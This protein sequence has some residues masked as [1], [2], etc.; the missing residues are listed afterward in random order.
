MRVTEAIRRLKKIAY[1]HSNIELMLQDAD[2]RL[3]P[4]EIMVI[5]NDDIEG[6][7]DMVL[8]GHPG[9]K[10]EIAAIKR[11]SMSVENVSE[12]SREVSVDTGQ[13]ENRYP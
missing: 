12:E 7:Q 8:I 13:F 6:I 1:K 9:S 2:G 11:K 10:A 3:V 4:A 5:G